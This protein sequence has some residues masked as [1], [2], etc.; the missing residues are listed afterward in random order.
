MTEHGVIRTGA[1]IAT[2]VL[3][4]LMAGAP[5]SLSAQQQDTVTHDTVPDDVWRRAGSNNWYLRLIVPA[6]DTVAGLVRY[7]SGAAWIGGEPVPPVV[8][9][10]ERRVVRGS[11]ALVG[12]LIGLVAGGLMGIG[13]AEGLRDPEPGAGLRGFGFGAGLG[14]MF[15]VLS[16][17]IA[18]PG[19]V[20]WERV[21]MRRSPDRQWTQREGEVI[22][23]CR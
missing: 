10:I 1:R 7:T 9:C 5:L 3:A 11:G 13:V 22:G 15:G 14:G 17:R 18:A 4:C 23:P 16:G 2:F 12:G 6:S 19:R 8:L 20:E 21:W